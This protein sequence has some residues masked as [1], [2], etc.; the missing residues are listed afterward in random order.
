MKKVHWVLGTILATVVMF[1]GASYA[2]ADFEDPCE[3][4]ECLGPTFQGATDIVLYTNDP[5][6]QLEASY[7][8]T[9]TDNID[10]SVTVTVTCNPTS[11]GIFPVGDNLVTCSATDSDTNTSNVQFYVTVQLDQ[12]PPEI[13]PP[14]TQTF[15]TTTI[16]AFPTLSPATATDDIDTEPTIT[17]SPLSF[18]AGT[19]TVT[20]TATDDAGNE[21]ATTSEVVIIDEGAGEEGFAI[22]DFVDLPNGCA[23]TDSSSNV[24]IFPEADSTSEYLAICALV[25]AQDLGIIDEFVVT[26]FPG[27]GLFVDSING[28]SQEGAY[29]ALSHNATSSEVGVAQLGLEEGDEI[30]FVLTTFENEPLDYSLTL[31]IDSLIDVYNNIVL[32]SACSVV[33]TASTTH[34]FSGNYVAICAVAQA[35]ADEYID[36]FD[37]VY[38]EGFGLFIDNFNDVEKPADTYWQFFVN[39]SSSD[40]GVT[41]AE[42]V[43]GDEISFLLSD[44]SNTPIESCECVHIRIIGLDEVIEEEEEETPPSGGGGG[45]G[46]TSHLTFNVPAALAYLSNK[47]S[48]DGSFGS[49]LLSDWAAIAFAA[50]DPGAAKTKLKAHMQTSAPAL[51]GVQDYIRHSMALMALGIDP[52]SGTTINYIAPIVSSFDGTQIGDASLDNDDIFALFPLTHAGYGS[53]DE[54]IS[55]SVAFIISRQQANGSWTG[56]VDVTA[57]AVQALAPLNSLPGVSAALTK[58]EAYLKSQQQNNGGFGNSSATSWT[59]QAIAALGQSETAWTAG[60][61]YPRDYLATLQQSDGGVELVSA[62]DLTRIWATEYAIPGATGKAWNALLSSFSKPSATTP[63]GGGTATS[64][65]TSTPTATTPAVATSTATSTATVATSSPITELFAEIADETP[66]E[67]FATRIAQVEEPT[68]STE[69]APIVEP[70]TNE[71]AMQQIAAAAAVGDIDWRLLILALLVLILFGIVGYVA[72]VRKY[73]R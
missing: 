24:H 59:M 21:A 12:I 19:T 33:D 40:V 1:G 13:T 30:S 44:F 64:T 4:P 20:W 60:G 39:E 26:E 22:D 15:S 29:W 10:A 48:T 2:H 17:Y 46:G 53:A 32:P 8:V 9:A 27:F 18:S 63:T 67:A 23:V 71:E 69:P 7:T 73:W 57:A 25:E 62:N 65:A 43:V 37:A 55:K 31:D 51:S 47:Q 34:E 14:G 52:Y 66:E 70:E 72:F 38:F 28:V 42:L 68:P 50:A 45:G 54:I 36:S 6:A 11:P 35:L 3:S 5:D 56:G 61:L 41:D 16:P 58:A 49:S